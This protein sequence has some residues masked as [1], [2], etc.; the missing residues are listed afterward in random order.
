LPLPAGA[1]VYGQLTGLQD[2][3][4]VFSTDGIVDDPIFENVAYDNTT[5]KYTYHKESDDGTLQATYDQD[6][7]LTTYSY[8]NSSNTRHKTA[9][10]Y[11]ITTDGVFYIPQTSPEDSDVTLEPMVAPVDSKP[12]AVSILMPVSPSDMLDNG[13]SSVN[14]DIQ[15]DQSFNGTLILGIVG[16]S[17]SLDSEKRGVWY[18]NLDGTVDDFSITDEARYTSVTNVSV[19]ANGS[20]IEIPI[21]SVEQLTAATTYPDDYVSLTL[22]L[23]GD[24]FAPDRGI[25]MDVEMIGSEDSPVTMSGI[26][27]AALVTIGLFGLVGAVIATPYMSV[28]GLTGDGMKGQRYKKGY[29]PRK[30][31]NKR[32]K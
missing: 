31:Y 6:V 32:R 15:N 9:L 30:K 28:E 18:C 8:Y 2:Q 25:Q 20:Q 21:S 12:T 4:V 10:P 3:S 16:K 26:W 29:N 1:Y 19:S 22:A 13:V 27:Q 7:I 5:D 23:D 17:S 14:V 24:T 11:S